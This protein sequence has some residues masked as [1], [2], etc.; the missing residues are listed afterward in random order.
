MGKRRAHGAG[1][2][3][4]RDRGTDHERWVG[5]ITLADGSR[6]DVYGRSQA[7]ARRKLEKLK[8]NASLGLPIITE[9]QTTGQFLLHW[10]EETPGRP[11]GPLP[12]KRT[13]RAFGSTWSR[14]WARSRLRSSRHSK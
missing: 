3:F 11:C 12:I 14:G 10:L 7:E 4:V 2:L 9:R 5:R 6:R 13:R 8:R 1:G